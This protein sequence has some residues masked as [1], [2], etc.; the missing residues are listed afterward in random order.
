MGNKKLT[1]AI[2]NENLKLFEKCIENG[3]DVKLID[4]KTGNS[5]LHIARDFS[6]V[7]RLIE[8][9]LDVNL[10]NGDLPIHIASSYSVKED[11]LKLLVESGSKVNEK[12]S[13]NIFFVSI[14]YFFLF[15]LGLLSNTQPLDLFPFTPILALVHSF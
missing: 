12:N 10:K 11:I 2:V 9:G 7:K 5:Y 1:K 14:I 13:V 8:L 4:Q 15:L 6:I 3:S